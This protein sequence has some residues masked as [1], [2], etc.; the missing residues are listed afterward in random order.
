M[1][2]NNSKKIK[3]SIDKCPN[4]THINTQE[5]LEC[6]NPLIFDE[7]FNAKLHGYRTATEYYRNIS[8]VKTL[9]QIDIPVLCINSLDDPITPYQAIAYDDIRMNPNIFLIVTER[10]SHMA[11]ISNE[12]FTELKQWNLKPAFE[13]LNCQRGLNCKLN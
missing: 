5:L 13:F 6:E 2:Q 4:L 7:I 8:A 9:S 10:G 3:N 1:E 11:F 12:K